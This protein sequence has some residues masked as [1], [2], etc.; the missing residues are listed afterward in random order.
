MDAMIGAGNLSK[1]QYGIVAERDVFVP[2]SDGVNINVDVFRPA[3]DAKF[4]ALLSMSPY[5]KEVQSEATC[6]GL[7]TSA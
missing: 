2:M 5:S 1:R 4:P 7:A 6:D 3:S